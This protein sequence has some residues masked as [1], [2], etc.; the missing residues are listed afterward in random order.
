MNQADYR[1]SILIVDDEE[2]A[3]LSNKL[4]LNRLLEPFEDSEI[5]IKLT[6]TVEGMRDYLRSE[7][8]HL[9]LIDRD[10]GKTPDN[11]MIDG[12]HEI[13]KILE[14]Q[15]TTKVIMVTGYN[16]PELA[17]K[18]LKNGA[19]DFIVKG[20]KPEQVEYRNKQI[21]KALNDSRLEIRNLR[22]S[23]DSDISTKGYVCESMAM[24]QVGSQLSALAYAPTPVLLLGETGLGK[25]HTAK[26]LNELSK[27]IHK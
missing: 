24:K 20:K 15:S 6:G 23:V 4:M 3:R 18:A 27:K 12:I 22:T 8:F 21:F 11:E 7:H 14:I 19:M 16:E 25:T 2:H 13:P 1:F 17:V 10:L 26:R 9:V 5:N